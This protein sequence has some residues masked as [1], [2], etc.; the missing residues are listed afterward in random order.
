MHPAWRAARIA[1]LHLVSVRTELVRAECY[2]IL[3]GK[4]S[5]AQDVG[6]GPRKSKIG[7]ENATIDTLKRS[8]AA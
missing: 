2:Y 5:Y 6:Q 4:A 7:A 8:Q 3:C 1:F